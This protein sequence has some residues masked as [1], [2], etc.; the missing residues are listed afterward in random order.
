MCPFAR[1]GPLNTTAL[2][3]AQSDLT[4]LHIALAET[5]GWTVIGGWLHDL[6]SY[7]TPDGEFVQGVMMCT[8]MGVPEKGD[9]SPSPS[10]Q[11]G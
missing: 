2:F 1:Q 6:E 9:K 11:E 4:W 5:D 3:S 10:A 8:A 7:Y